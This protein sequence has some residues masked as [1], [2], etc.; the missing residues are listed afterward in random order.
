MYGYP[1][2]PPP[3][4][5]WPQNYPSPQYPAV[6]NPSDIER[7]FKIA[8]KLREKEEKKKAKAEEAKN[9]V[10]TDDKKKAEEN[11]GKT[12]FGIE[13]YILGILSYP[14]VGPLYRLA[15]HNLEILQSIPGVK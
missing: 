2:G 1:W 5:M 11:K 15:T 14:I 12:L 10:K 13:W 9:K 6:P 3:P 8:V 4:P 7:G